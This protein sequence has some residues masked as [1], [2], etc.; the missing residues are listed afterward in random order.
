MNDDIKKIRELLYGFWNQYFTNFIAGSV[1]F[2]AKGVVISFKLF[3][4]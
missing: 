3:L 1:Y 2:R 4:C